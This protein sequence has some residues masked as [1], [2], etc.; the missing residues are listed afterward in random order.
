MPTTG[1]AARPMGLIH[2]RNADDWVA[3]QRG[4]QSLSR[5]L[6]SRLMPT[7]SP[8]SV[9]AA[10]PD[11]LDVIVSLRSRNSSSTTALIDPIAHLDA[12]AGILADEDLSD[13]VDR[14]LDPHVVATA[15][16]VMANHGRVR[17]A[18]LPS[19][20]GHAHQVTI[21]STRRSGGRVFVVQHGLLTPYAPPLPRDCTLLAWSEADGEFWRSGRDDVDVIVVGSQLLWQAARR[22]AVT[23]DPGAP[24]IFLGQLHAAEL[25]RRE[26]ARVSFEFCRDHGARYRP[27]PAEV[28]KVSRLQHLIWRRRGVVFDDSGV[29]LDRLAAPVVAIFST[30]VLEAAAAGRPA[31]VH[32]PDPPRWVAE[33]WERYGLHRWGQDPTPAP[34]L[35][36]VEPAVRVAE[37]LDAA[38]QDA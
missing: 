20:I 13:L 3:W 30:G 29:A 24:L 25:P 6:R 10:P 31:W 35:P 33:L 16:Q 27:H 19:G 32:H 18:A 14:P 34:P 28:D 21:E 8:G 26:L 12:R 23:V 2:P 38:V 15:E 11:G 9:L 22:P 37:I 7:P 4:G 36:D 1:E 17:A 5:R